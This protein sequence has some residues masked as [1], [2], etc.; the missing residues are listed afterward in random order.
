MS[1]NNNNNERLLKLA[2]VK[3]YI[4][5]STAGIYRKIKE[6]KFPPQHKIGGTAFWR[7]SEIQDY[8]EKGD[9]WVQNSNK[10]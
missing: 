9:G 6:G 4:P 8:I 1:A 7:L 5:M 3:E 2:T 10:K